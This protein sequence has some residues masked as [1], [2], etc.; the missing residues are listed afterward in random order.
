MGWR[1]AFL[2]IVLAIL[3][4]SRLWASPPGYWLLRQVINVATLKHTVPGRPWWKLADREL[5][6]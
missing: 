2:T 4:A 6:A 3:L 1:L 5:L